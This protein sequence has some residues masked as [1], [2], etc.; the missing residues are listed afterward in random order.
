MNPGR[1]PYDPTATPA[2]TERTGLAPMLRG[3]MMAAATPLRLPEVSPTVRKK[4]IP[5]RSPVMYLWIAS[6]RKV[7][8]AAFAIPDIASWPFGIFRLNSENPA[9]ATSSNPT[10][11]KIVIMIV[12]SVSCL[13]LNMSLLFID[14]INI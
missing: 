3:T 12:S 9:S 2:T 8:T 11:D 14:E 1:I 4:S 10:P 7:A 5:K 6:T 13:F